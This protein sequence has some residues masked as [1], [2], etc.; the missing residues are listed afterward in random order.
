MASL[1]Y[2]GFSGTMEFHP[3]A[4]YF[5]GKLELTRDN[6]S[7]EAPTLGQLEQN[8]KSSVD[9]YIADCAAF[10]IEPG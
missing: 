9:N 6:V 5:F 2:K 1:C 10:G 7:Y 4:C 3:E 8:F